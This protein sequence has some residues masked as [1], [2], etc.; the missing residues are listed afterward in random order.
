MVEITPRIDFANELAGLFDLHGQVAYIPG[1]YGGIGEAISWGL[2]S[3]GAKV[4]VSGRNVQRANQFAQQLNDAGHE[5]AGCAVDVKSVAEIRDSVDFVVD[6]YGTIDILVNSTG[7]QREENLLDVSEEAFDEVYQVNL[8]AAMF[9]GQ[10]AAHHQIAAKRGGKQM[11]IL[12]VRSQLALRERGYSAYSS[13]KGGLVMLVKQHAM[14]LAPHAI[15][16]NGIAPTFVYT[17]MIRHVMENDE[18]RSSLIARIPLGR[19]A[20]PKDIVGAA[21]FFAAPASDFITGQI[22]YVDGGITAS[23]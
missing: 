14:E 4:V 22:L 15:N 16:V 8:K 18:F 11:H 6:T 1:G 12:S 2:A 19:I 13:T 5:A 9:L 7:I 21:T 17:E 20:N 23:Q 10:A 3:R